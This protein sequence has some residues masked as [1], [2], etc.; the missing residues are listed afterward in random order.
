MV[1]P[2]G[3]LHVVCYPCSREDD[4]DNLETKG[5]M[6]NMLREYETRDGKNKWSDIPFEV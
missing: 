6:R 2:G 5:L 4:G 3:T 1:G